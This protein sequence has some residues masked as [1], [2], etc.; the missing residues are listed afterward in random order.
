MAGIKIGNC[1]NGSIRG[2]SGL[3]ID[4]ENSED[5]DVTHNTINAGSTLLRGKNLKN[6]GIH[7]NQQKAPDKTNILRRAIRR[8]IYERR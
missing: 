2:N 4:I 3:S 7:S 5:I 8:A 6:V 1:K